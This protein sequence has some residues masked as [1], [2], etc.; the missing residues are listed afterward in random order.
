VTRATLKVLLI[1]DRPE[2]R[3][4]IRRL[5]LAD[6]DRRYE[7]VEAETG[8]E[9]LRAAAAPAE[10]DC[11]VLDYDLPDMDCV[12][13]LS[14]LR[15]GGK[16]TAMPVVVLNS[17]NA[18]E[19]V[20]GVLRAGAMD[21]L[22]KGSMNPETLVRAIENAIERHALQRSLLQSVA[23]QGLLLE[24]AS[25]LMADGRDK[26]AIAHLVFDKV[27]AYFDADVC[28]NFHVD[29]QGG[30]PRLVDGI[31]GS[32]AFRYEAQALPTDVPFCGALAG[33]ACIAQPLR[34]HNARVIGRFVLASTRREAFFTEDTEFLE[35]LCHY[36]AF[37]WE[38]LDAGAE[39]R[40]EEMLAR[41][42]AHRLRLTM[43][44][45]ATGLWDWDLSSD[46]VHWSAECY[47]IHGVRED[48]F[49]GTA[50]GFERLVHPEDR[51]RVWRTVNGAIE[52]RDT[53]ECAFRILR[54]DGAQ[55]W[56]T[57]R[58]R[59]LYD[60]A[61]RP[62]RMIGTLVD[63]TER[64]QT[65]LDLL[66]ANALLSAV[67]E[68]TSDL[69][70]TKDLAGR[71]TYANPATLRALG[72]P[73]A[74]VIG[75]T[76]RDWCEDKAEAAAITAND[77]RVMAAGGT[78]TIEEMFTSA[79]G[80]RTFLSVKSPL[81][82]AQGNV[83]GLCGIS[84]DITERRRMEEELRMQ[85]RRK[86]EFIVTLGH[87]LR[88]PL[89]TI[90]LAMHML[91]NRGLEADADLSQVFGIVDRQVHQMDRLTGDLLDASRVANGKLELRRETLVLDEVLAQAI[92]TAQPH[93]DLAR[94]RVEVSLPHP[95]VRLSA[96]PVRLVQVFANLLNNATKYGKRGGTVTVRAQRGDDAVLV[97][98]QD[99]GIGI[100]AGQLARVFDL[101]SQVEYGEDRS[102]G[103]LGIGLSLTRGLVELHGGT[104]EA[105]SD[106][107][108]CGS[109]FTV[110]L[111]CLAPCADGA[112][113]RPPGLNAA[114]LLDST[115]S[116]GAKEA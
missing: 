73:A 105:E 77:R 98:V 19:M 13:V 58:G 83:V 56:V 102:R 47:A 103:G 92:E 86:N 11:V 2:D 29:G 18:R 100:P 108:G 4:E 38:R 44:A 90:V 43:E 72:R 39:R 35:T 5:L 61:G 78:E 15:G 30:S 41:E 50:K 6:S 27:R 31:G 115:R 8:A 106:G 54:P 48:E 1:E 53:Y 22:G 110:R 17:T 66:Q 64:R 87:E 79:G 96:D 57:N 95:Q 81:R 20:G 89:A 49:D 10:F 116:A 63:I 97:Q 75:K 40:E 24:V 109:R 74:A 25:A 34:A 112:G 46:A 51:E 3:A 45:T 32:Q 88:S 99:D 55:R 12:A 91:R 36:I 59:A 111:P 60:A 93:I 65:E 82:D 52:R 107:P 113:H 28:L 21:Y 37:S 80:T 114:L 70:F 42:Q 68:H 71:M 23:R 104:I 94:Q 101:F 85:K 9:G 76:S 62:L 14:A 16:L 33:L 69:I 7:F 67:G 84:R 26:A